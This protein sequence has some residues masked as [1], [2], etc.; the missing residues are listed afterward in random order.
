MVPPRSGASC[1]LH[2]MVATIGRLFLDAVAPRRCAGCD[3]VSEEPICGLCYEVLQTGPTPAPWRLPTVVAFAAFEF[4][5]VV[6][7]ILHRGKFQG[8]RAALEA[9]SRVACPRL[10]RVPRPDAVLAVPL[11]R[12]RR[13]QRG[14]NQ[15]EVIAAV[16]A[17]AEHV[18]LLD[19][20]VRC[21]ETAPQA[22][23]DE[24]ARLANIAG[25]FAWH[26]VPLG[27][28]GVWLVDDVLTTGATAMAAATVLAEA[29]ARRVT[30]VVLARVL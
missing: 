8:D 4:D 22:R 25:A 1:D 30:A 14:Y 17:E 29:G 26:G 7:E 3:A 13:R 20:L 2:G 23:R 6:R 21:R 19:G 18:P 12:R 9:L 28:A 15:A 11:G 10:G 16:F 27:S 5:G 24:A